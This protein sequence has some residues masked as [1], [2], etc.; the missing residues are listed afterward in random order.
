MH[1]MLYYYYSIIMVEKSCKAVAHTIVDGDIGSCQ[2]DEYYRPHEEA[3]G[4]RARDRS[5]VA[6]SASAGR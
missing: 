6:D 4:D 5:H 1:G 2:H 3:H